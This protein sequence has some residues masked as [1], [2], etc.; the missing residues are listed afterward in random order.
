MA[1]GRCLHFGFEGRGT[2]R[3]ETV[4]RWRTRIRKSGGKSRSGRCGLRGGNG[5]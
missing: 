3:W 4:E 2:R 5:L 1:W